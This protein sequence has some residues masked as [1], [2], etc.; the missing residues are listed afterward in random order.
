[1]ARS[2]II[3]AVTTA[4]AVVFPVSIAMSVIMEPNLA[5]LV[6]GI[7]KVFTIALAGA[8]SYNGRLKSMIETIP[9][10]A[11]LQEDLADRF[12]AWKKRNASEEE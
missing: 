9:A 6:K 5:T 7:L 4:I 11:T 2:T 10:Y 3:R 1:M 8:K 12:E